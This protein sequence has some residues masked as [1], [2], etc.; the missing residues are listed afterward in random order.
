[1]PQSNIDFHFYYYYYYFLKGT[2]QKKK[3]CAKQHYVINP[4]DCADFVL[5]LKYSFNITQ[6]NCN[7]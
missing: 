7:V 3:K 1:M 4:V 2:S 6:S 5:N